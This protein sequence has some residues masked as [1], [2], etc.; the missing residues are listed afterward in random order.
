MTLAN[1]RSLGPRSLDVTCKKCGYQTKVNVDAYPGRC[2]GAVIWPTDAM[3]QVRPPRRECPSRL[4]AAARNTR[5][6][7]AMTTDQ[8]TSQKITAEVYAALERLGADEELLAIVGSMNDT[9]T[10]KEVL[11][12]LELGPRLV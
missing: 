9:M 6:A 5:G 2:H 3:Q 1:M 11:R 4:V 7:T 12:L 10:D 8:D